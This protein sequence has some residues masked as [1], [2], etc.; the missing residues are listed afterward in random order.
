MR[1][2]AIRSIIV[3]GT[4]A[5]AC[6]AKAAGI[7]DS[8]KVSKLLSEAKTMAF[9]LKEDTATMESFTYMNVSLESQTPPAERVA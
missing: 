5:A 3:A 7:P 8:E 1:K 6:F 4:L 9:Q 2:Y